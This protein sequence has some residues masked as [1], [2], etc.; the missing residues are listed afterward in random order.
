MF[1]DV[2]CYRR[3]FTLATPEGT[4]RR[5]PIREFPGLCTMQIEY[6]LKTTAAKIH[7][8][9]PE[10]PRVKK[11]NFTRKQYYCRTEPTAVKRSPSVDILS[12]RDCSGWRRFNRTSAWTSPSNR[13]A[14][15]W[16][17]QSFPTE[18]PRKKPSTIST[19][20]TIPAI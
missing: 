1:V 13:P 4:L 11:I 19:I 6:D 2:L 7:V 12:G 20:S 16:F 5:A 3:I 8:V 17:S 10:R 15:R 9:D 18:Y 14:A